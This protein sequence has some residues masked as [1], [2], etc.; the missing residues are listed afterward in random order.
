MCLYCEGRPPSPLRFSP[1]VR[2]H[3]D[4]IR[5]ALWIPHMFSHLIIAVRSC[6]IQRDHTVMIPF[7]RTTTSLLLRGSPRKHCSFM[8]MY[9]GLS[10][11]HLM[12]LHHYVFHYFLRIMSYT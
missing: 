12:Y 9:L 4:S 1:S 3:F 8:S 11:F 7:I 5:V 6:I 10:I 2:R